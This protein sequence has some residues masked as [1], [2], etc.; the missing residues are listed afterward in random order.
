MNTILI[1]NAFSVNMLD[2]AEKSAT[3]R[4]DEMDIELVKETLEDLGFESAVG[5]ED[6]ANVFS[7][8]LGLDVPANR[9]TVALKKGDYAVV[10]QY[11]GPRLPEGCKTLPEG[12]SIVWYGVSVA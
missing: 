10:G 4:F 3:V 12:A 1:L 9:A 11:R 2:M 7:Q 5:H 6:T 8:Q